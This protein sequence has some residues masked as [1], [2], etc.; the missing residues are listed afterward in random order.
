MINWYLKRSNNKSFI[1]SQQFNNLLS[2]FIYQSFHFFVMFMLLLLDFL[3]ISKNTRILLSIETT[4]WCY[5]ENPVSEIAPFNISNTIFWE[6]R[7]MQMFKQ[8]LKTKLVR[9]YIKK[10]KKV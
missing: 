10:E 4:K 3:E 2:V 8:I 7:D 5:L 6:K 9:Y 1:N